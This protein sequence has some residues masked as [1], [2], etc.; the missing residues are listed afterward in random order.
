MGSELFCNMGFWTQAAWPDNVFLGE[1][2]MSA[3]C[4]FHTNRINCK[5]CLPAQEPFHWMQGKAKDKISGMFLST[6]IAWHDSVA[7]NLKFRQHQ[8]HIDKH[9][10]LEERC[11]ATCCLSFAFVKEVK[12]SYRKRTTRR[13]HLCAPRLTFIILKCVPIWFSTL[14]PHHCFT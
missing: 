7:H 2:M 4:G 13:L 10:C 12:F 9:I 8:Y 5:P 14:G 6:S 1:K 3:S 11:S